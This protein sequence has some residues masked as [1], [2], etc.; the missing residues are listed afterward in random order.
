MGERRPGRDREQDQERLTLAQAA[1]RLGL[2]KDGVRMRVRR[3]TLH[4]EKGEDGKRYVFV[5]AT[6][7]A[8]ATDEPRSR[9]FVVAWT[10]SRTPTARTGGSSPPSPPGYRR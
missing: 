8:T 5:D 3:G 6:E 4:S 10:A 9:T 1:A 2:S 7:D